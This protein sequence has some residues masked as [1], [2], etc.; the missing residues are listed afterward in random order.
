MSYD[1]QCQFKIRI[2]LPFICHPISK[3]VFNVIITNGYNVSQ[4]SGLIGQYISSYIGTESWF[5]CPGFQADV[6]P[7][8][9][10]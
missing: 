10:T 7:P 4:S 8:S 9:V 2:L 3:N 6:M 1:L 5:H